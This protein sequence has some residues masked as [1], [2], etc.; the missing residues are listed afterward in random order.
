MRLQSIGPAFVFAVGI[1]VVELALMGSLNRS[2][3]QNPLLD[4]V[5]ESRPAIVVNPPPANP[6]RQTKFDNLAR[7]TATTQTSE[8]INLKAS[9]LPAFQNP[10]T[11]LGLLSVLPGLGAGGPGEI[12]LGNAALESNQPARARRAPQPVY[13]KTALRNKVEGYVVVRL[14]INSRGEVTEVLVVDSDP[15]GVFERSA[16]EAAGRFVFHPARVNGAAV[17]TTLEKKIVFTLK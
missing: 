12:G 2:G 15:L 13:P 7:A 14:N 9:A 10:H 16:R 17:A 3:S 8:A 1:T 5:P 6:I 11:S 4:K